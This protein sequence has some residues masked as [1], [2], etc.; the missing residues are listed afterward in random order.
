MA[1]KRSGTPALDSDLPHEPLT[2]QQICPGPSW[3]PPPPLL[4][5][6]AKGEAGSD[7]CVSQRKERRPGRLATAASGLHRGRAGWARARRV[8]AYA[9]LSTIK[10]KK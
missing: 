8:R 5:A 4:S 2:S 3:C 7:L 1:P 10:I 6:W 9:T